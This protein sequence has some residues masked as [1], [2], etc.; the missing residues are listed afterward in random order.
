[1][2][3]YWEIGWNGSIHT[4][5]RVGGSTCLA[6]SNESRIGLTTAGRK[7]PEVAKQFRS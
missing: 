7:S 4:S 3:F 6:E 2:I 5:V 1:M